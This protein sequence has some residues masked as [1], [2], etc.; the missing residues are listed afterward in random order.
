MMSYTV[1]FAKVGSLQTTQNDHSTKT[2]TKLKPLSFKG[3]QSIY[4]E[5]DTIIS[6]LIPA[7]IIIINN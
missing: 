5:S 4:Q 3:I 7:A 6:H 1:F 2:K